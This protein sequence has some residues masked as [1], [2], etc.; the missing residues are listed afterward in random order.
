MSKDNKEYKKY[1]NEEYKPNP[2]N[3]IKGV[4]ALFD[5]KSGMYLS[6][7]VEVTDGTAIRQMQQVSSQKDSLI[8]QYPS[9]YSLWRVADWEDD[10][11]MVCFADN[12]FII[13]I[14][15]LIEKD[16]NNG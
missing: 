7:F 15:K 10:N 14:D 5:K 6:P 9:D 12:M 11:G 8:A 13:E 1:M 16:K 2:F 3:K 4:F